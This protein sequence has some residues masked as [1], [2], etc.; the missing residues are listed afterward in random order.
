M[1]CSPLGSSVHGILQ[2]RILEWAAMPSARGYLPD[3]GIKT[4]SPALQ[5]DSFTTEPRGKYTRHLVPGQNLLC[6]PSGSAEQTCG[7][8]ALLTPG[9]RPGSAGSCRPGLPPV[10]LP[11][12]HL[13]TFLPSQPR[14]VYQE[15]WLRHFSPPSTFPLLPLLHQPTCHPH[16]HPQVQK[17]GSSD[18]FCTFWRGIYLLRSGCIFTKE[19]SPRI[20][21]TADSSLLHYQSSWTLCDPSIECPK[22]SSWD[23]SISRSSVVTTKDSCNYIRSCW[24]SSDRIL[25]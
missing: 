22:N 19:Y 10:S 11:F 4:A 3:P 15:S 20:L 5:V 2:A 1:D 21:L 23:P 14:H 17:R 9:A 12:T 6:G 13:H 25:L 7:E 8:A 18:S 24:E 16:P